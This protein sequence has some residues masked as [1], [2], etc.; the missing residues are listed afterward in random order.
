[1]SLAL[2][3]LGVVYG[4]ATR[5]RLALYR[6]GLFAMHRV[7]APVI[8]VG[9]I[10]AGGTGKTPL[11]EWLAR[12]V[13]RE[14]RRVC[15]L[16]RGYGRRD[17]HRRVVV[18]DGTRILADAR[19]GGDEPRLLA[20]NLRGLAAVVADRNR[21]AAARW[22]LAE[23]QSEVFILDDGFQHL[24]LARDLDIVTVD[25][26]APWGG[27]HLL[28]RGRL[29]EPLDGLARAHCIVITRA[30]LAPDLNALRAKAAQLSAGRPVFSARTRTTRVRPLALPDAPAP[31]GAT[32]QPL[33]AF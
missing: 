9:N 30:E 16:T 26:S 32:G 6:A 22:A 17:A 8:S 25:A 19:A 31:A 11:V 21:V 5:A 12:A 20:E 7:A 29:R 3:P 4:A 28:P 1:M 14:G 24:S 23:L 15:V 2:A 13:A 33:A 18:S 27:G 10:T